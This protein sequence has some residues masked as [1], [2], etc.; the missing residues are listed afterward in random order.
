MLLFDKFAPELNL[1]DVLLLILGKLREIFNVE[2]VRFYFPIDI[3][4]KRMTLFMVD[5]DIRNVPTEW[6]GVAA[7]VATKAAT[8]GVTNATLH[9]LSIE[10]NAPSSDGNARRES[11]N[12]GEDESAGVVSREVL[13]APIMFESEETGVAE[14]KAVIELVNSKRP[15]GFTRKDSEMLEAID[16][17]LTGILMEKLEELNTL[18]GR[19]GYISSAVC[20]QQFAILVEKVTLSPSPGLG[21]LCKDIEK[22]KR[23]ELKIEVLHGQEALVPAWVSVPVEPL[24]IKDDFELA[25]EEGA[26]EDGGGGEPTRVNHSS[27]TSSSSSKGAKKGAKSKQMASAVYEVEYQ[28]WAVWDILTCDI[29]RATRVLVTL[30]NFDTKTT[31][32]Y[33]VF[34]MFQH[35]NVMRTTSSE[36]CLLAGEP[37]TALR[38]PMISTLERNLVLKVQYEK[39]DGDQ[40]MYSDYDEEGQRQNA[41]QEYNHSSSQ[42]E[43]PAEVM[44]LIESYDMLQE[45]T[46]SQKLLCWNNRRALSQNPQALSML[47]LSTNWAQRS[48]VMEI[49]RVIQKSRPIDPYSA[50]YLL[51]SR[52]PDPKL[53]AYAVRC[54]DAFNDY[55]MSQVNH[56][57]H[58][59]HHPTTHHHHPPP[60]YH[61]HHQNHHHPLQVMLQLVQVLKFEPAHDTALCR[62]LL[63]RSLL[64]P[65]IVGHSLYWMLFTEKVG[66]GSG[67]GEG[68][69][70]GSSCRYLLFTKATPFTAN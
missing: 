22:C 56:H 70:Q 55:E 2:Q 24:K 65:Q 33:C 52:F 42:P 50:L 39:H 61:H 54:L 25:N 15:A 59:H 66:K 51:D 10:T 49:Y 67:W 5:N 58:H 28:E 37:A 14:V 16:G 27:S 63:R 48:A 19:S 44:H 29:P 20:K 43:V 17:E 18:Q 60:H 69:T 64:N 47:V 3:K 45:L 12:V 53:R 31:L 46:K 34:P 4:K 32:G 11:I 6:S 1:D 36:V 41:Q 13:A 57:H 23:A 35:D 21:E 7:Q 26:A 62:F 68:V 40:V 30:R 38:S 9:D 8:Q